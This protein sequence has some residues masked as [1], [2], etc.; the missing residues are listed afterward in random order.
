M[1]GT[2]GTQFLAGTEP[3]IEQLGRRR[4]IGILH[5]QYEFKCQ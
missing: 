5:R 3:T 2:L 1:G 4:L